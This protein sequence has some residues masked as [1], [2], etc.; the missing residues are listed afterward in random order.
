MPL[1]CGK[2]VSKISLLASLFMLLTFSL[3]SA[4][5]VT[6][7]MIKEA[8]DTTTGDLVELSVQLGTASEPVS[9]TSHVVFTFTYDPDTYDPG[10]NLSLDFG[11]SFF[12]QSGHQVNASVWADET[13]RTITCDIENLTAN[14]SGYGDICHVTGGMLVVADILKDEDL[15]SMARNTQ[16]FKVYPTLVS[17][18]FRVAGDEIGGAMVE[19]MDVQGRV[20]DQIQIPE[21]RSEYTVPANNL[22]SGVYKVRMAATD[23]AA[24]VTRTII[25]E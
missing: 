19:L 5:T 7:E 9:S 2:A 20:L 17:D 3:S 1:A 18:Y 24:A 25:K 14:G 22:P 16:T 6:H 12:I 8:G 21:G 10:S 23:A 15:E 4:Q 13:T 11:N